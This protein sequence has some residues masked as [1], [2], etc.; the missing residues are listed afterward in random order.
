MSSKESLNQRAGKQFAERIV[1][2]FG[3]KDLTEIALIFDAKPTTFWNWAN[4][5]TK[6]PTIII[7]KIATMTGCSLEWLLTGEGEKK[8]K[9]GNF[10]FNIETFGGRYK[11]SETEINSLIE[12]AE[13]ENCTLEE[14]I[15]IGAKNALAKNGLIDDENSIELIKAMMP[16][17]SHQREIRAKARLVKDFL[18]DD[19]VRKELRE[20]IREVMNDDLDTGQEL[21]TKSKVKIFK[22]KEKTQNLDSKVG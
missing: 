1:E 15:A 21:A 8:Y 4:K 22:E 13:R 18:K 7:A 19:D 16:E 5:R 12:I 2:A 6:I 10:K 17:S 14:I 9:N 20:I 11:F 3:G